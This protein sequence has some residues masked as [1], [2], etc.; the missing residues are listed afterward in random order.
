MSKK[1]DVVAKVPPQLQKLLVPI[2]SLVPDPHNVRMHDARNLEAIRASY[3]EHGQRKPI[4][5]KL[6]E[7]IIV[8][9]NGQ[10]EAARLLGWTHIAA[11]LIE[12]D[13]RSARRFALRDNRTADL[14]TW[15]IEKLTDLFEEWG[16]SEQLSMLGFD[17]REIEKLITVREHQRR[18]NDP[19]N[20]DQPEY[21][22]NAD[23]DIKKTTCPHCGGEVPL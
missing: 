1:N 12:E 5:V 9:G 21:D 23:A 20:A 2:D 8:A 15:N 19:E 7:R 18:I 22:E 10:I 6:P 13:M 4:V 16:Q 3:E 11:V 17:E 14:A